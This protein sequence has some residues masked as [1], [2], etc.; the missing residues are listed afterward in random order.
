MPEELDFGEVL[1]GGVRTSSDYAA[2]RLHLARAR[3]RETA[4]HV[5]ASFDCLSDDSDRAV[6]A[7]KEAYSAKKDADKLTLRISGPIDDW[8][9]VDVRKV[10]KD[11]DEA[12]PK[13]IHLLVESPGGFLTDGIALYSELR[14][15]ARD[16][17]KVSSETRG[18][19]ASAAVLPFLAADERKVTQESNIMIHDAWT[20]I[21]VTGSV[22]DCEAAFEQ[23]M[24]GFKALNNR[25]TDIMSSRVQAERKVMS[26]W[27]RAET[28]FGADDAL[29][30]NFA[31]E[32]LSDTPKDAEK[33]KGDSKAR[34][35]LGDFFA[36]VMTRQ[37]LAGHGR[38]AATH[39]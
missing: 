37:I 28:W 33:D 20:Y 24:R 19:V 36:A 39:P 23:E 14:A 5:G 1:L 13:A 18:L 17:V 11:I 10:I 3:Y 27:M 4:A 22:S 12:D 34:N 31:T 8:Y 25:L 6:Q 9:G 29:E 16:G 26:K 35:D 2:R 21:M 7:I 38:T 15:R 30:N 32:V